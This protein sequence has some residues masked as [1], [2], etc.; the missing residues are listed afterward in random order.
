[1]GGA[2]TPSRQNIK[3]EQALGFLQRAGVVIV[4]A[5]PVDELCDGIFDR[6][7]LLLSFVFSRIV[8]F[9]SGAESLS[10]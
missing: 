1:V 7:A 9:G 5:V 10:A 3:P 8:A 2:V 6:D 4:T